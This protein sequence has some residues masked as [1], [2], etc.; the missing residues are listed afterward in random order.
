MTPT[1]ATV[2][3]SG[4]E[5]FGRG[6]DLLFGNDEA[7]SRSKPESPVASSKSAKHVAASQAS[8]TETPGR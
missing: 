4:P 1:K 2:K 5:L 7:I 3:G 6:I 8:A